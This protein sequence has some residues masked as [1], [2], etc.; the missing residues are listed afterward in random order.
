MNENVRVLVVR[1]V[2]RGAWIDLDDEPVAIEGR[3]TQ[4]KTLK[5]GVDGRLLTITTPY[6]GRPY[7]SFYRVGGQRRRAT[8]RIAHR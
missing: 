3:L 7:Q 2:W 4:H 8:V 5:I 1:S 6:R